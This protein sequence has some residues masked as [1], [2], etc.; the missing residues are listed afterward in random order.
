MFVPHCIPS[1][2][3]SNKIHTMSVIIENLGIGSPE[4]SQL[5]YVII[6]NFMF[7]DS[8]ACYH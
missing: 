7:D 5:V 2:L 1:V 4:L 8:I 6:N 3:S